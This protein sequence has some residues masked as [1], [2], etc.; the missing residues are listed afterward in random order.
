MSIRRGYQPKQVSELSQGW[1]EALVTT[2][3]ARSPVLSPSDGE[4]KGGGCLLPQGLE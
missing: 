1:Q 3:E 4:L 2:A